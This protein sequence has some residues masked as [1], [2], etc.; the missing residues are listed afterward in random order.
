VFTGG[1]SRNLREFHLGLSA[2]TCHGCAMEPDRNGPE[3]TAVRG[4]VWGQSPAEREGSAGSRSPSAVW[5]SS[6]LPC[7]LGCPHLPRVG[8]DEV[9]PLA[10]R[11]AR[12]RRVTRRPQRGSPGIDVVTVRPEFGTL[13]REFA[14]RSIRWKS[15]TPLP[16]ACGGGRSLREVVARRQGFRRNP[17]KDASFNGVRSYDYYRVLSFPARST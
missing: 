11:A 17:C 14:A 13:S 7:P 12:D 8:A 4:R 10:R 16:C 1:D 2:F 9:V 3:R 5:G 6:V 15:H